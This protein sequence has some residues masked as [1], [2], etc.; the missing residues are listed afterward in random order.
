MQVQK[1]ERNGIRLQE[2]RYASS[3][4][5]AEKRLGEVLEDMEDEDGGSRGKP[6]RKSHG[7]MIAKLCCSADGQEKLFGESQHYSFLLL[8][9]VLSLLS[10]LVV[11]S[12]LC[13][14]LPAKNF[15]KIESSS[16]LRSALVEEED[17]KTDPAEKKQGRTG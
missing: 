12:S 9:I 3:A 14:A 7:D 1:L 2:C 15:F 10:L 13:P 17:Q 8:L 16:G 11:K 4:K 5:V 6:A